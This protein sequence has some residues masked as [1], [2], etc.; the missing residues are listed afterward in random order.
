MRKLMF[1]GRCVLLCGV[2]MLL[3]CTT[4]YAGCGMNHE[5]VIDADNQYVAEYLYSTDEGDVWG[6]REHQTC[7]ICLQSRVIVK[8]GTEYTAPHVFRFAKDLGHGVNEHFHEY[9]CLTCGRTERRTVICNGP[10]CE[11]LPNKK[12][13]NAECEKDTDEL[14]VR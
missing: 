14:E 10:P 2:V 12:T 11:M 8:A 5:Y 9:K 1:Y 6:I 4:A 13:E 7:V 3:F